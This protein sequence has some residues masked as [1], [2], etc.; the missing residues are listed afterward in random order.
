MTTAFVFSIGVVDMNRTIWL[1]ALTLLAVSLARSIVADEGGFKLPSFNP[2]ASSDSNDRP[3]SSSERTVSRDKGETSSEGGLA[4]PGL[5]KLPS[6]PK[7]S[8]PSLTTTQTVSS[9][10]PTPQEPSMWDKVQSGSKTFYAKTKQTLMPWTADD[11]GTQKTSTTR[12]PAR[13][14]VRSKNKTASKPFFSSWFRAKE[15]EKPIQ[16]VNDFLEQPRVPY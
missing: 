11:T 4:W 8:L 6:L 3:S 13:T 2:F 12:R 16:S 5:P 10:R 9:K 14:S 15:D 1:M 7:L